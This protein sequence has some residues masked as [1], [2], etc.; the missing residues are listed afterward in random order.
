M[1]TYIKSPRF[2]VLTVLIVAAACTRAFPL[3]ISHIWHFTAVGALAIFAGAKFDKRVAFI[4]PLAA[5]ALSDLFIG[6]GFSFVVYFG[7]VAMV[8]CGFA[9]RKNQSA[10]NIGLAS[11][12]GAVVFFLITNFAF[13]YPV[14]AYPHNLSGIAA[15]Y[16][17]GLPFINNMIVGNLVF[18]TVLF[19]AFSMLERR[20]PVIAS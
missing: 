15:A 2:L 19:G 20:F 10:A 8:L 14:T 13:F 9:I 3:F 5:M 12:L 11:I 18:G 17:A 6:N 1:I 4:M 7:F 16:I